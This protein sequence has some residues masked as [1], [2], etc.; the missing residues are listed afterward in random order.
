MI[1]SLKKLQPAITSTGGKD[2]GILRYD[3][4]MV[5]L[6]RTVEIGKRTSDD[7]RVFS[8]RK[9]PRFVDEDDDCFFELVCLF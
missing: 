3:W 6:Q 7:L 1:H 5:A 4:V 9:C 2:I 8:D